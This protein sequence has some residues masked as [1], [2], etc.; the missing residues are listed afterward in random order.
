MKEK[1]K[2][3]LT[4][5]LNFNIIIGTVLVL[6]SVTLILFLLLPQVIYTLFPQIIDNEIT[7]IQY[8]VIN[9]DLLPEKDFSVG[10]PE[11]TLPP[12]DKTLGY[13]PI[14]TINEIGIN[15]EIHKD[16]N[17][18]I[19]LKNGPWLVPDLGDP[20]NNF[21]PTVI[22]SHRWGTLEWSREERD[23]KSFYSL[24]DLTIGDKIEITWNRRVFEYEVYKIE[25]SSQINDYNADLIL[26]TCKVIWQSP[27]R[28]FIYAERT[29]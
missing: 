24:P 23:L 8:P 2:K 9:E 7:S 21:L 12:I 26:Y 14:L 18:K 28:I 20:I 11:D 29:N 25:E 13:E 27:I 3:I 22:A 10:Q 16:G 19:A 15:A 4:S 17:S 1:R 6:A 5:I